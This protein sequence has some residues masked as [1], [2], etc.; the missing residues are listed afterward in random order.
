MEGHVAKGQDYFDALMRWRK[1][2]RRVASGVEG[3]MNGQI[4][5]LDLLLFLLSTGLFGFGFIG[6]QMFALIRSA[7]PRIPNMAEDIRFCRRAS[8]VSFVLFLGITAF[9]IIRKISV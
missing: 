2:E 4:Q 6:F 1:F 9:A 8:I 5:T 3:R 7:F